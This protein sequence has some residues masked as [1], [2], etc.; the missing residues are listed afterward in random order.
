MLKRKLK[1]SFELN[2][3]KVS[4][5]NL[6]ILKSYSYISNMTYSWIFSFK[7]PGFG[8]TD[9]YVPLNSYVE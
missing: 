2:I 4:S 5:S 7:E 6:K 1:F 8:F 9:C 3:Y